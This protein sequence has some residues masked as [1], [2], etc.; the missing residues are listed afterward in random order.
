[1]HGG[2][3]V[4][5]TCMIKYEWASPA[6]TICNHLSPCTQSPNH[7]ITQ[8]VNY[9]GHHG[10]KICDVAALGLHRSVTLCARS[11]G[12]YNHDVWPSPSVFRVTDPR[13]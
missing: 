5:F 7:P 8:S 4:V 9:T 1:M 3:S 6:S 12:Q 2:A 13:T 10:S 11:N